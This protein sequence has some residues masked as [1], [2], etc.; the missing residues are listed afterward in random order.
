MA[1]YKR[2]G[3]S[4]DYTTYVNATAFNSQIEKQR[5]DLT[6]RHNQHGHSPALGVS[7]D[8][9]RELFSSF[10]SQSI[11]TQA[12]QKTLVDI[13]ANENP[14]FRSDFSPSVFKSLKG[15]DESNAII[16]DNLSKITNDGAKIGVGP[17]L[18]SLS[19]S[20][21]SSG[22]LDRQNAPE[23]SE[24]SG[25]YNEQYGTGFGWFDENLEKEKI[26]GYLKA[27]YIFDSVTSAN[28][29]KSTIQG[30]R[31]DTVLIDYAQPTVQPEG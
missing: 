10:D 5:E 31:R 30:E 9:T 27:K 3:F 12:R 26:G 8:S 18:S 24:F 29:R 1:G 16:H 20:S 4:E 2:P 25:T 7:N 11:M 14:D 19:M 28:T 22:A 13:D 23:E 21:A 17:N 15:T 6:D